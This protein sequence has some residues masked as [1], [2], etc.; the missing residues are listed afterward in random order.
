MVSISK[1]HDRKLI[2]LTA[3]IARSDFSESIAWD[4]SQQF[5][6]LGYVAEQRD[7]LEIVP[8]IIILGSSPSGCRR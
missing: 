5:P 6:S 8:R 1:L 2:E 4:S 7:D 3:P